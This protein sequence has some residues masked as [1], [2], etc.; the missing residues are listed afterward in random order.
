MLSSLVVG[1]PAVR[2]GIVTK[3]NSRSPIM[4]AVFNGAMYVHSSSCAARRHLRFVQSE[5]C[6]RRSTMYCIELPVGVYWS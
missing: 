1:L 4:K 2:K 3:I 5:S 6:Y